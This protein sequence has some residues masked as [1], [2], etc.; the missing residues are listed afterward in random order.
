MADAYRATQAQVWTANERDVADVARSWR[1]EEDQS[2]KGNS[3]C[4]LRQ[5][6]KA[7][8]NGISVS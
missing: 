4:Q 7:C 5:I 3:L 8:S 1:S 6:S 2:R